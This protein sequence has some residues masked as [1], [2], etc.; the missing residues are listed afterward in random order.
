MDEVEQG[1]I[2]NELVKKGITDLWLEMDDQRN[3]NYEPPKEE[4]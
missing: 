3:K 2:P 1:Y 4:K